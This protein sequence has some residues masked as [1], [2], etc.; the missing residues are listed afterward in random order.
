MALYTSIPYL[1]SIPICHISRKS[2]L[3]SYGVTICW[4]PAKCKHPHERSKLP[5]FRCFQQPR[6]AGQ[7]ARYLCLARG[8]SQL[9]PCSCRR[10]WRTH[11]RTRLL[12][13]R[14]CL[15]VTPH[16]CTLFPQFILSHR[17]AYHNHTTGPITS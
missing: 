10:R 2:G 12:R 8:Y 9:N 5:R 17:L 3:S 1:D 15:L 6:M 13:I 14:P 11:V 4:S 16:V 7:R